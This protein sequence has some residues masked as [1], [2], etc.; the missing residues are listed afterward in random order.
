[1]EVH[2][3]SFKTRRPG[4]GLLVVDEFWEMV[5]HSPL[6]NGSDY[7]PGG[8]RFAVKGGEAVRRVDEAVFQLVSNG[9]ILT[10]LSIAP[11]H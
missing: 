8:K 6:S 7:L 3:R 2:V 4:G 11:P 5:D 1:M 10:V 9:E